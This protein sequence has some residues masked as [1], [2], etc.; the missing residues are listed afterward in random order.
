MTGP[1]IRFQLQKLLCS[2]RQT[3]ERIRTEVGDDHL[4]MIRE[5]PSLVVYM[6]LEGILQGLLCQE[7]VEHAVRASVEAHEA[8]TVETVA[9][10]G[11]EVP[12]HEEWLR[13][14]A[15]AMWAAYGRRI[16]AP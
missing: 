11:P 7:D 12:R 6:A 15:G 1:E 10:L 9:A 4:A 5:R 13:L 3:L 16:L 14:A 8:Q 2:T